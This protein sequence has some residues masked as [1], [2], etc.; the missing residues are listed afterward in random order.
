MEY[1]NDGVY[2]RFNGTEQNEFGESAVN[3]NRS[4][5]FCSKCPKS[6]KI[7]FECGHS[8]QDAI[9]EID[10]DEVEE[11]Q[12]F[13]LDRVRIDTSC[14]N[15]PIVKIEFSSLIAFEAEDDQ[16]SRHEVEVDLLFSLVRSC[17]RIEETLQTWKYL[18]K[19][20]IENDIDELKIEISEPFTVT[21]CDRA[22]PDCCEYK[23]WIALLPGAIRM[24]LF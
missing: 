12:K 17:N 10:D 18:N 5:C 3:R 24:K 16:G 22:C 7:L 13:V 19:F 4:N 1:A 20:N 11:C 14:L 15:R 6:R 23:V 21:F 2:L 8:P 9:F